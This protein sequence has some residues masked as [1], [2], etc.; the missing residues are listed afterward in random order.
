MILPLD[1]FTLIIEELVAPTAHR[2]FGS[3]TVEDSKVIEDTQ[4]VLKATCLTCR[5]LVPFCQ[6]EIF[7]AIRLWSGPVAKE[8]WRMLANLDRLLQQSPHLSDY[9]RNLYFADDSRDHP[10]SKMI[11]RVLLN[12]HNIR[13][14]YL[15]KGC[16]SSGG[17]WGQFPDRVALAIGNIIKLPS[18]RVL[19]MSFIQSIPPDTL[20]G[21]QL[22]HLILRQC[23]WSKSLNDS[24]AIEPPTVE[25]S[26]S[27][28]AQSADPSVVP[29]ALS[30]D[31]GSN[32]DVDFVL[33][34][35]QIAGELRDL[36][37][38][39]ESFRSF[40]RYPCSPTTIL[41]KPGW[42]LAASGLSKVLSTR[43]SRTLTTLT[44]SFDIDQSGHDVEIGLVPKQNVLRSLVFTIYSPTFV[45]L[46]QLRELDR[47]ITPDRFPRLT[48]IRF[49]FIVFVSLKVEISEW[50]KRGREM[51]PLLSSRRDIDFQCSLETLI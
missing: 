6:R 31:I 46:E 40:T 15:E 23:S 25:S 48:E 26:T 38:H 27:S 30:V 14:F 37:W 24:A 35:M 47:A 12:L 41:V 22:Q 36:E 11:S 20:Q 33:K 44:V 19:R 5:A 8:N 21:T 4:K 1:I 16:Y 32:E 18:L 29:R 43:I 51:F 17:N 9:I 34:L 3:W 45:D 10:K 39:G 7:A 28:T 50:V 49:L 2:S 13:V 42:T